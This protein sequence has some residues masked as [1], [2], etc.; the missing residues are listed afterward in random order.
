MEVGHETDDGDL[1]LEKGVAHTD[2]V[3]G[4]LAEREEAVRVPR[5]RGEKNS[6]P[7][8]VLY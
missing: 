3:A 2:A 6:L 5:E 8:V 1:D 4:A 7:K